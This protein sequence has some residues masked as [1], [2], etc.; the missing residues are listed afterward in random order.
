MTDKTEDLELFWADI[1]DDNVGHIQALHEASLIYLDRDKTRGDLWR[2]F[3]PSDKLRM[4]AEKYERAKYALDRLTE[5]HEMDSEAVNS[6]LTQEFEDA[7]LDTI[8]FATFAL[9]QVREGQRG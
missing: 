3:P 2:K 6:A 5:I 4:I 8:N 1:T 9:R 7:M